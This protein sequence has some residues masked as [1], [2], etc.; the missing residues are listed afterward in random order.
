[1][2]GGSWN[3][4]DPENLRAAYRNNDH[5]D[6]RNNN[7]GF[8]IA[9]ALQHSLVEEKLQ[10]GIPNFMEFGSVLEGVQIDHLGS[11]TC[12]EPKSAVPR[13]SLVI[14]QRRTSVMGGVF[15]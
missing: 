7:V 5:P 3:N 14:R 8:R 11:A 12:S 10:A 9:A 1:M 13:L 6:N 15:Y 2:R 4:Q